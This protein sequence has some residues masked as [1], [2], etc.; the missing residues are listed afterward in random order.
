[1]LLD[2]Y[3]SFTRDIDWE[4][5]S[6]PIIYQSLSKT[7]LDM[8]VTERQVQKL[9]KS[10]FEAGALTWHDSGNHK[11]YGKR[12]PKNGRILYAYGVDLTP[13]A[14]LKSHLENIL[15]EKKLYDE[16][17]METK[18][19]ISWYRSQ[20]RGVIGEIIGTRAR[21]CADLQQA[22][23]EIAVQIRTH[24]D[25]NALRTLLTTHK[26]L[27]E[28]C[29]NQLEN[30]PKTQKNTSKSEKKVAHKEST[31]KPQSDKSEKP[32]DILEQI[33]PNQAILSSSERL[34]AHINEK[35]KP[36]WD[37]YINAAY[38][39]KDELD[40]SQKS[41]GRACSTLGRVG[42]SLCITLTDHA[43][44]REYDRITNAG[45]Y[46][47]ALLNRAETGDLHLEPSLIYHLRKSNQTATHLPEICQ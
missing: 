22:Y 15:H 24:M 19:Q 34:R 16:A 21:N 26:T 35:P 3:M 18:R 36:T 40:I 32:Q 9:E 7:A 44:S 25:L 28:K 30:A 29:I 17:W 14:Y 39:M 5:G 41:W 6:S 10:L 12:D 11:R 23:N 38:K 42:A 47:N 13:L 33:S 31:I 27:Y 1:M 45:G 8:G 37:D 46:F 4:E 20:I 2:Y 43:N